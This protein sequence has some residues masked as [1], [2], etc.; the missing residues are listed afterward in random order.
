MAIL[1]SLK[2]F[3]PL[4]FS[5]K[6]NILTDN[7]NLTFGGNLSKRINR[8]L[9][10]LEE[11]NFSLKHVSSTN[12]NE[13]D[14]LSRAMIIQDENNNKNNNKC[15]NVLNNIINKLNLLKNADISEKEK[16]REIFTVLKEIHIILIH[17]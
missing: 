17:P 6:V 16:Q 9:L 8:W 14:I 11:Y 12:N 15:V 7:K 3:K 5:S 1:E 10:L 4:I 13:A 2:H